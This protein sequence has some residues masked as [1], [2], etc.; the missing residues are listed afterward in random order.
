VKLLLDEM[1]SGEVAARLRDRDHDVIAVV[2]DQGLKGS[3]DSAVF[4]AAQE[5]GRAVVTY[6]RVDFEPIVRSLGEANRVHCGLVIIN[7]RRFPNDQ[8][9]RL[10]DALDKLLNGPVLQPGFTIWL[11]G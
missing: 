9:T 5:Q 1:I 10:V 3:S 8:F 6:N 7:S 4:A 11:R 2:V